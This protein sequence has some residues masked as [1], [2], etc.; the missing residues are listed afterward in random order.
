MHR[1]IMV[2]GSWLLLSI[3]VVACSAQSESGIPVERGRLI[4]LPSQALGEDREIEISLPDGYA[5][6]P[7]RAYPVLVVLDGEYEHEIA[8]AITRF[9]A[10]MTPMPGMIVAGVRNTNRMR[11][12]T[13]APM[14]GFTPPPA[15]SSAGGADRFLSFLGDELLPYLEKNYRVQPM[16]VLV[17]HS[18]GGLFAMYAL[19]R[20]PDLFTG[21]LVMEPA[22]WWNNQHELEEARTVLA[23]AAARRV[24]VM[25]VNAPRLKMD[26]TE[27]GGGA[28]MIRELEV[29][30]ETHTSMALAGMMLGLRTMFSDFQAPE[31]IP[32][33]HPV[34]MLARYDS[35][36]SRV[37]FAIPIPEMTFAQV[38]RMSIHSRFFDDAEAS[39]RRMIE[40][41]GVTGETRELESMLAE[42]RATPVPAGFIPLEIP[43]RRPSPREAAAFL[44]RWSAGVPGEVHEVS[45]RASGD[46][47]IV[48]DRVQFPG[49]DWDDSDSP[50]IQVTRDGTLEWGLKWFRG[51][52]ALMVMQGRVQPDGTMLVSRQVRGWVPRGPGGDLARLERFSR[53]SPSQ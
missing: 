17:G 48:H 2:T 50:V 4:H 26:T 45:V 24:R 5:A 39:L 9:Y 35:L 41:Y 34:A 27:W 40:A 25:M 13:P 8:A 51:I 38:I 21:Y 10:T 23:T 47:I 36:A 18:L 16:R 6:D 49:G 14:A 7:T 46:T 22:V 43:A 29:S 28:P 44:G 11:D 52:A 32:G 33:T 53:M 37:G 31:W 15:V 19:G 30:G 3:G 20:K 42:E 12:M 1:R